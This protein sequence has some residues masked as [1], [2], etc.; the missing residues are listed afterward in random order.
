MH[1]LIHLGLRDRTRAMQPAQ[2]PV[3]QVTNGTLLKSQPAGVNPD[4]V[5]PYHH[6][7][8]KELR[9][10][11]GIFCEEDTVYNRARLGVWLEWQSNCLASVKP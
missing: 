6:V 9:S 2:S 11:S 5:S 7:M 8:S 1:T 4:I 10:F 3:P